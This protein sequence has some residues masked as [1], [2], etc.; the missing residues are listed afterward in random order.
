VINAGISGNRVLARGR[1]DAALARLDR[2][3]LRIEGVTHLVMLEGTND[4]G[5]SGKSVFGDNPVVTAQELISGYRQIIA[6]AHSR[7]IKVVLGTIMPGHLPIQVP[8]RKLCARQSMP[9]Y[10]ALV[11]RIV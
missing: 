6:R 7:G 5:M 11:S 9:G 1:G 3:V 2:D 4:I 8:K 10:E